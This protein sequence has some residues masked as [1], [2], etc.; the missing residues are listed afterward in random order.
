MH[1]SH[2]SP[3]SIF[4]TPWT[5]PCQALLPM[6]V[7]RQEYL[8]ELPCPPPQDLPDPG[9]KPTYLMAPALAGRFFTTSTT[10]EA[11]QHSPKEKE[12]KKKRTT[13]SLVKG[14]Y[15]S[16]HIIN[17]YVESQK[18]SSQPSQKFPESSQI[19][20]FLAS[21]SLLSSARPA[22]PANCTTHSLNSVKGGCLAKLSR[23]WSVCL[24]SR[25]PHTR[26]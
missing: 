4:E 9:I 15:N 7:S 21:F 5:V 3:V 8:C 6:G 13:L 22:L 1:T 18:C 23:D 25:T 10:W 26:T 12:K 14:L 2:F 17:Q 16:R 24:N 11:K 19:G 20:A